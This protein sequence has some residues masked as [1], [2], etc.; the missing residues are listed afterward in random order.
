MTE[1]IRTERSFGVTG[2][3]ESRQQLR[4]MHLRNSDVYPDLLDVLEMVCIEKETELINTNPADEN[5]V[6]ANHKMAKA[7]WQIFT[8]MQ[9][10]IDSE[11]KSYLASVAPKPPV[12]PLS[13]REQYIE[14]VINATVPAPDDDYMGI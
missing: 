6:L 8:Y 1:P 7:A 10:K 11:A 14:H 9:E 5:A 3:L 12:P 4:L 2:S 13:E